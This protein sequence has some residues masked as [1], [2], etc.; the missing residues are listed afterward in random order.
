MLGDRE[1][2]PLTEEERKLQWRG[3]EVGLPARTLEMGSDDAGRALDDGEIQATISRR[4]D[5]VIDCIQA[6]APGTE[7]AATVTLKMLVSASGRVD[8]LRV[9]APRYLHDH[10]LLPCLRRA[11]ASMDFPATGAATVVSAPFDLE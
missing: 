9:Q 7:L 8:R 10:G 4:G 2:V 5:A 1:P 11:A 6:A 3:D